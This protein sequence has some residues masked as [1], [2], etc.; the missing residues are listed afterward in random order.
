MALPVGRLRQLRISVGSWRGHPRVDIRHWF[1]INLDD[2]WRAMR[3]GA[4][5]PP[6]HIAIVI[7]ALRE[8]DEILSGRRAA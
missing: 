6:E 8:A 7:E 2:G 4:S 5:V 1:R 3:A